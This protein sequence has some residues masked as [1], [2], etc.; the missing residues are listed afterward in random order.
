MITSACPPNRNKG[1]NDGMMKQL[2][3]EKQLAGG[4][5]STFVS[6]DFADILMRIEV[7][8]SCSL[9]E[10]QALEFAIFYYQTGNPPLRW[11]KYDM[12]ST[13]FKAEGHG[14]G[15]KRILFVCLFRNRGKSLE[16]E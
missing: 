14:L 7:G 15:L 1:I 8:L 13:K 9:T 10:R 2:L 16:W 5:K 3:L 6:L 11:L 4:L 12:T